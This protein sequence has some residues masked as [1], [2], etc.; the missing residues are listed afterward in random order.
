MGNVYKSVLL[1]DIVVL[2]MDWK[3]DRSQL[4]TRWEALKIM[5]KK[6]PPCFRKAKN[7]G[8]MLVCVHCKYLN[9]CLE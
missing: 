2:I 3:P 9:E 7:R 8:K 1:I 5:E 4:V 6:R